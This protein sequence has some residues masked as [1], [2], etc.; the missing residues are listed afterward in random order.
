MALRITN[1]GLEA[2]GVKDT[3]VGAP[4]ETSVSPAPKRT[5]VEAP[6]VK[7]VASR[8]RA[9]V[10]TQRSV[11][12][13]HQT[14]KA[15][16]KAGSSREGRPGSK[17][18]QCSPCWAEGREQRWRP[19][20]A[21]PIGS[22]TRSAA[23]SP[24]W[25]ARSSALICDP[26]GVVRFGDPA[27]QHDHLDGPTHPERVALVRAVRAGGHR[28]AHS[29]Q[30]GG[31]QAQGAVGRR[32]GAAGIRT[33]GWQAR[34]SGRGGRAGAYDLYSVSRAR[35]RQPAGARASRAQCANKGPQAVDGGTRGGVLFTQGPLFYLLRNR[36]YI[37]EVLYKGEICP[38]P[39]PPLLERE[40]FAAVQRRLTEQRSH[41]ATTR[42]KNDAPLKEILFDA[43][44]DP[45]VA[46]HATKQGL[47][48]RYYV[49]QPY[50]RGLATPPIGAIVRV[51]APD[52]EAVVSKA[53][54]EYL[55]RSNTAAAQASSA[56]QPNI[57]A[58]V[59][60][61]EVRNSHLA[62]WLMH[63]SAEGADESTG[64]PAPIEENSALLIPWTKPPAKRFK[65]ILF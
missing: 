61:I 45:M 48:Y 31:L 6:E 16:T 43:A 12:T 39:Q 63:P 25:C 19:S 28:R 32:N 10:T 17:Q 29:G 41:H 26:R 24:G 34:H 7:V 27:V 54:S 15:K 20:C 3:A 52:I 18:A 13:R 46:T 42:T 33:Q 21:P 60:R 1:Q 4:T 58:M 59:A 51:P 35:Q 57:R 14:G 62:V 23:S 11:R 56:D 8:K 37:G 36:F 50:L 30:G 2:I 53:L 40:L 38:G 47:R 65:E 64:P 44:G 9:S 49:S 55:A 5:E 22:S